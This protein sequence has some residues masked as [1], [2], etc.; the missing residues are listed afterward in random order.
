MKC[1]LYMHHHRLFNIWAYT[2]TKAGTATRFPS[3][4]P[5]DRPPTTMITIQCRTHLRSWSHSN[6]IRC[7]L[8]HSSLCV[9]H[10]FLRSCV[11]GRIP[12]CI[13]IL[14]DA[15]ATL[16]DMPHPPRPSSAQPPSIHTHHHHPPPP[17]SPHGHSA[18][19]SP[20]RQQGQQGH[21]GAEKPQKGTLMHRLSSVSA[22]SSCLAPILS[23][24]RRR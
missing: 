2:A 3:R 16:T 20:G 10:P 6:S 24:F 4:K 21:H 12:A 15:T 23:Y 1:P 14:I 8:R 7:H 18:P 9:S 5:G 11:E 19:S 22:G 17:P 13:Y